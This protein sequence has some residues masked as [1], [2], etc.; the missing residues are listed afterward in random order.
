MPVRRSIGTGHTRNIFATATLLAVSELSII[1]QNMHSAKATER[2]EL[3]K[4]IP[5]AEVIISSA[6]QS[7]TIK[8]STA[9]VDSTTSFK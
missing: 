4:P 9:V 1:V 3:S 2:N 7:V 5:Q 8:E 6:G